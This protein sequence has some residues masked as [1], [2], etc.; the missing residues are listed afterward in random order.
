M[1]VNVVVLAAGQG[2][3]MKSSLPKVLHPLA[4]RP[5]AQHVVD[6]A[7]QFASDITLVIGHGGE[8]VRAHFD[9]QPLNFAV[10]DEQLGTGHAV[11][12]A[13]PELPDSGTVLVL[14]GDVPLTRAETLTR[15]V[16]QVDDRSLALLTV[17][18]DDPSGYGR[19]LRNA[20]GAVQA[21][22]EEKDAS[23]EQKA[24][25]EVNSGIMAMPA[26]VLHDWLPRL[27]NDNAQGEYYLTDLIAMAVREGLTVRSAEPDDIEET[28]GV[29][30]RVQLADLERRYQRRQ[31][32]QLMLAGCSLADPARVDVRGS[33]SVGPDCRI[34]INAVFEGEVTLGSGVQ[35]GPNCVIRNA[36]LGDG[37]VVEANTVIDQAELGAGAS[38]GPFARIRPGTQLGEGAKV[39]NF[40]ETKNARVEAGAKINHLS[41]VGD[42]RVG[43]GANIGAGTITCNYDGANKHHTDIG[44]GVFV[45]SNS[46]LVAPVA[47]EDGAFI[48]AGSV[49]TK[50]APADQLSIGRA[51]QVSISKWQRPTK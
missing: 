19:I 32:E 29:N 7:R 50:T 28:L 43:A 9:G 26:R 35:I 25:Q 15:L 21:I 46:T 37:V 4:G 24:I 16:A 1:D 45:G 40:V 8:A 27:G 47:L 48:G 2:S 51:R 10:Q 30:N 14:Y 36:R 3:R 38:V 33:L 31:A 41:Y 11:A 6:T 12:Q 42:A 17:T 13:L 22:V 5:L 23:V 39:G 49:I 18:L 20:A 34:D 44:A